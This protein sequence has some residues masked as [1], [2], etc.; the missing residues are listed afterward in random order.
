MDKTNSCAGPEL[1][2]LQPPAPCHALMS[3]LTARPRDECNRP[4]WCDPGGAAIEPR[5]RFAQ[6]LRSFCSLR[7]TISIA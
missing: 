4:E 5:V 3:D 6:G 1:S 2:T 7:A